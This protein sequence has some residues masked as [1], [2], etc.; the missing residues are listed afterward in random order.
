MSTLQPQTAEPG[1]SDEGLGLNVLE[2]PV[3]NITG[4]KVALGPTRS[5]LAALYHRWMN[6]FSTLRLAGFV[7]KPRTLEQQMASAAR[8]EADNETWFLIY[9]VSTWQPIGFAGLL[10]IDM[11]NRTAE[12]GINIGEPSARGKGYGTEAAQLVLDYAFTAR[13]LHSVFLTTS[14]YNIAGQKAYRK[15]GFK[16]IGRRRQCDMTGGRF[17]DLIYMDCLA[18]EFTSPVLK[19][20]LA[21]DDVQPRTKD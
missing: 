21:P 13:G 19:A 1:V 9:E 18:S 3:I 7:P 5:D 20:I 10:D 8:P 16:E 14:E 12:F 11:H 2:R 6:D 15:A 17:W 4:E